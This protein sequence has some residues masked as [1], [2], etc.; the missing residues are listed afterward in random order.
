MIYSWLRSGGLVLSV[1]GVMGGCGGSKVIHT[2]PDESRPHITWEIRTGGEYG[3]ADLVCGS[4]KPG[5][6]CVLPS[7]ASARPAT[8]MLRLYLHAAA[9]QTN[10]LGVW[11]APFL[12][13]WTPKDYREVSGAIRPGDRPVGA[14]VSGRI[15]DKPGTYA[16]NVLLDAAQEGAPMGQRIVLD[17]PVTVRATGNLPN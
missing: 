17:I 12:E 16:F 5:Q 2:A 6:A 4:A 1:V 9:V 8:V 3:D 13:G 10:Y 14:S 15:T 11:R 7:G